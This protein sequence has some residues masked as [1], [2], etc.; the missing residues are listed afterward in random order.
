MPVAI[1]RHRLRKTILASCLAYLSG[2]MACGPSEEESPAT[3]S[4][5]GPVPAVTQHPGDPEAGYEALINNA[6]V[7]CGIPYTAYREISEPPSP[8][9]LLPGREG[10]NAELPY[11]QTA[12]VTEDGVEL[13]TSNCLT[14]HAAFFN[15]KLIIGLG[16][17]SLDFTEDLTAFA[18]SVGAYVYEE[19]EAREWRKWADR[20][21]A[22][23]P[24]IRTETRGVNPAD[25][26]TLALFVHHDPKTL[27]W[28][29]EPLLAP[30]RRRPLPV[31][32]P[33]WW[34]MKKKN[35]MFYHGGG[36]GD[37]VP[38]MMLASTL[39]TDSVAQAEQIQS[40]FPDI[41]AFIYSLE[42]PKYPFEI[43]R[44][45]AESGRVSFERHCSRCH[46]TYGEDSSYPNL[47]I[48]LEEV[49]T[50]PELALSATREGGRF[51]RWF[52]QSFYGD[53]AQAAPAPGYY[54]PPLDGVWAT[55][56]YLH[57]GS[58]P[59][60]EAL[61]DS[62]N[63]PIYWMRSFDST[64]YDPYA[65]GWRYAERHPEQA[66]PSK[67]KR[68][69]DTTRLGYSKQGHT[70]GDRLTTDEREAILEYLKTL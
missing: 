4:W 36:R 37:H 58:V 20:I 48:A 30:P 28:S 8:T 56:P 3:T 63:R 31:S 9:A 24:Y 6:Y 45:L 25:N 55:A 15:D 64:D 35:A 11:S 66:N 50:D 41:Q 32:V 33:P 49:G 10:R 39:C 2:L 47:V 44:Q 5:V 34:R 38:W 16:N 59:T 18:E 68:V 42:P 54:A 46:G 26:L 27:R 62:A 43:D 65:L 29:E 53:R 61:L 51:I 17:E 70:Y 21:A 52:N 1:V 69:Y 13:V 14:C 23:A 60:I 22:I 19:T 57:N 67:D 40:Y 12:Y 7:T